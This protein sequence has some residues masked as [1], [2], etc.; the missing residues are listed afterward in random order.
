MDTDDAILD[1]ASRM[2]KSTFRGDLATTASTGTLPPS[3][4]QKFL[5]AMQKSL[6][7]HTKDPAHML[8]LSGPPLLSTSQTM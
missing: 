1:V 2:I 5:R 4:L 6:I 8:T 7:G 3:D